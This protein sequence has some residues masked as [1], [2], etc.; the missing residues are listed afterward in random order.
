MTP[1]IDF[2]KKNGV[3]FKIH[4][5]EHDPLNT[6]FGNE[7]V[8]KL[9]LD[10][11]QVFK[12]LLAELTPKQLVVCVIPVS[13]MLSLKYVATTFSAKKAQMA[14][15]DEAQKTTGYLLGGISPLGQKKRLKTVIDSTAFNFKTIYVSGGKRG[16]DIELSANDLKKLLNAKEAK[17]SN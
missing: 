16:L 13:K 1:A 7:A 4:K 15:K 6:N 17:I 11:D 5:Y 8:E 9:S 10:A 12:T 3:E 2:L 14:K